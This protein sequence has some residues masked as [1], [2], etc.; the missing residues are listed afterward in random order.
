MKSLHK[1]WLAFFIAICLFTSSV[2]S[3]NQSSLVRAT[4][5]DSAEVVPVSLAGFQTVTTNDFESSSQEDMREGE[6]VSSETFALKN[7][8]SFHNTLLTLKVTFSATGYQ[9][10]LEFC[11]MGA[12]KACFYVYPLSQ[13]QLVLTQGGAMTTDD[14][15]TRLYI[16]GTSVTSTI[17]EEILLQISMEYK[18]YN[19]DGSI[20]GVQLGF[21]FNGMQVETK[22][23]K[24]CNMAN[25]G[26]CLT[27]YTESPLISVYGV[28]EAEDDS[29]TDDEIEEIQACYLEDFKLVTTSSFVNSN[30]QMAD[31]MRYEDIQSYSMRNLQTNK[32]DSFDK[33]LLSLK[34]KFEGV[35]HDSRIQIAGKNADCAF[36]IYTDAGGGRLVFNQTGWSESSRMAESPFNTFSAE[37]AE[38]SSFLNNEFILQIS[39]EY[40]NYDN[41]ASED[42]LKLG[43]YFN[44]ALYNG[45]HKIIYNCNLDNHGNVL[46]VSHDPV[47]TGAPITVSAVVPTKA[48][49]TELTWSDFNK[50]GTNKTAVDQIV[51]VMENENDVDVY[52]LNNA[53]V[54]H[55]ENTS[56]ETKLMFEKGN[57]SDCVYYAGTSDW[58]GIVL[59]AWNN[60]NLWL[61]SGTTDLD[62]NADLGVVVIDKYIAGV[63]TF[64]NKEFTLRVT[65]EFGD[66]DGDGDEGDVQLGL[67]FNGKLYNNQY[68]YAY[69]CKDDFGNY[70]TLHPGT[71]CLSVRS[72]TDAYEEVI[73]N[74][75]D[76]G[77]YTFEE[78]DEEILV[79]DAVTDESELATPG[80]YLV[81]VGTA[82]T[83]KVVLYSEY[84][85]HP[86]DRLDVRDLVATVKVCNGVPVDTWSGNLAVYASGM[87]ADS[88]R[89]RLLN[90]M[91]SEE[92][93]AYSIDFIGGKD[94]MPIA[95]YCGPHRAYQDEARG[96]TEWYPNF[97][98]D[99]YYQ[100]LSD[101]GVNLIAYS[102]EDYNNR[103]TNG[104]TVIDM[105]ELGNKYGIG[106]F[107]SDSNIRN[108]IG[109]G[110]CEDI[111]IANGVATI[112]DAAT[113]R[114]ADS[115]DLDITGEMTIFMKVK[116]DSF[117][118]NITLLSKG[119][120]NSNAYAVGIS[121]L[122]NNGL[123]FSSNG[124]QGSGY[125]P[126]PTAQWREVAVVVKHDGS[127]VNASFYIASDSSSGIKE[128]T[129]AITKSKA[130]ETGL[131]A[132]NAPLYIGNYTVHGLASTDSV[133][134]YDDIRIYNKALTVAQIASI[135]PNVVDTDATL[136][137]S[138]VAHW[139]FVSDGTKGSEL[140]DKATA[141]TEAD[142]LSVYDKNSTLCKE[143]DLTVA[144]LREQ[145]ANYS[146]Y[147]SFCGM[148]LVD[149][150]TTEY[151]Q[152][153][154][155]TKN[156]SN[157]KNLASVLQNELGLT[158]FANM[159]PVWNYSENIKSA[160]EQYVE[161]FC[162]S[163]R[164]KFLSWDNYPFES[165]E[166]LNV[167]FY[168]MSLVREKA[169]KYQIPFW[170]TI[171]AG[172]Q[173]SVASTEGVATDT[174]ILPTKGEFNWNVN[175][176][177]AFG[178]QGLDYYPLI[179]PIGHSYAPNGEYDYS[180]NGVIGA[181]GSLNNWYYYAQEINTHIKAI[182]KVLMNSVNKG[183]IASGDDATTDTA[184]VNC[185]IESGQFREL[186]SVSG[187]AIIG[188]FNY[189]GKTALYVVNHNRD[190]AENITLNFDKERHV[191]VVRSAKS[192]FVS[193]QQL[194]LNLAAGE[195]ALLIIE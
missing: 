19:G 133:R 186:Q 84:D 37:T 23:V 113:L 162:E 7:F 137:D 60:G 63:G 5:S 132:N 31:T 4:D 159:F 149:E 104:T 108:R 18:D 193:E 127:Y 53:D 17:N 3:G 114:A 50:A 97:I 40:G 156:I 76:E 138:L 183:V 96:L 120:I 79:N 147:D 88:V 69:D 117:P 2:I 51:P 94:V 116:V 150:P 20:D 135:T 172:G 99:E 136:K 185:V 9:S 43:F 59:H 61:Q 6:Y 169:Q 177:L 191:K 92:S 152:P 48:S 160:Y 158:V 134:E 28:Q 121:P 140:K 123:W 155:G 49:L 129:Q 73:Q 27:V 95:G 174:S 105:L 164:P 39:F 178:V 125:W 25:F 161:E 189:N 154:N 165:N 8:D 118:D 107:L 66:Y 46:T 34:V 24:N 102:E 71:G 148:Y 15:F 98:S 115:E 12:D 166:D 91:D 109:T 131:K 190:T 54:D 68:L 82:T 58:R 11:G 153:G 163:L 142:D 62:V 57:V 64:V 103:I 100:K 182:D 144:T 77:A 184:L 179:Q 93:K 10:R 146:N 42:D 86:D 14:P 67:Y 1:K 112:K 41:G 195:G 90:S 72:T 124:Y 111:T 26:N 110:E 180:R 80:D 151:Y 87:D 85:P 194:Q 29:N 141:G 130:N 89:D 106:H 192:T 30:G 126:Y 139:D 35:N 74:V 128:D 176:C 188:C 33:T 45:E 167:Y 181:D 52:Y 44:G 22:D 56:Y 47:G 75:W 143:P 70:I 32:V 83:K 173:F 78:T 81:N 145:I 187:E 16:E 55:M 171:Q 122:G 168:N 36:M 170:A 119:A 157:Y 21:Y 175:T 38:L 65:T 13:T 101:A